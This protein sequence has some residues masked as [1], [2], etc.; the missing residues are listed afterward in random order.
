[1]KPLIVQTGFIYVP[2][3]QKLVLNSCA[4]GHGAVWHIHVAQLLIP[5]RD[6][7]Y[8]AGVFFLFF[9]CHAVA[10]L[11]CCEKGKRVLVLLALL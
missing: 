4:G 11:V 8:V 6:G 2:R 3:P 7:S 1:M 10:N 5:Q 9:R